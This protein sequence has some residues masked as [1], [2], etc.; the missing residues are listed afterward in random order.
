MSSMERN[1]EHISSKKNIV[2]ASSMCCGHSLVCKLLLGN[3]EVIALKGQWKPT[4]NSHKFV[5]LRHSNNSDNSS[6]VAGK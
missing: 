4:A 5:V 6:D 1:W 2:V 3:A